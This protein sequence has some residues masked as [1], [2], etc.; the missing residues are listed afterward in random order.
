MYRALSEIPLP[1]AAQFTGDVVQITSSV[2]DNARNIKRSVATCIFVGPQSVSAAPAVDLGDVVAAISAPAGSVCYPRRAVLRETP[3][4]TRHVEISVG[5]ALEAS[6]EVTESHG[7]FY[8]DEF[9]S[10]LSFAPSQFAFMYVA[11]AKD[12]EQPAEKFKFTPPLGE[13]F[14]GKKQPA[15]FVFRWTTAVVRCET[16]LAKLSPS[17]IPHDHPVLF[18]QPVFS[19][20]DANTVYATGY[21]YTRDGR[22]LGP[23]WCYNRPSGIWEIAILSSTDDDQND[24]VP[25]CVVRKLTPSE[26]SCRSPRIYHDTASEGAT[27]Y[28]LS[29]ASG[30]PHAGTFS[31]HSQALGTPEATRKV[32]VDTVWEPR[33]SD[34]FPGLY[35]D[36]NLPLSPF[37]APDGKH[38]FLVF[39]SNWGSRT[40]VVLVSTLDGTVKDLTPDSDGKLFSWTVLA[41]DGVARFV[42]ARSAPAIP[43]EIVLGQLDATGNV[44]WRVIHTPHISPS[45]K[46]ALSALTSSVI[47]IPGRGQTQTMVVRPSQS[48][49]SAAP[50]CIQ[51]IHGGPHGAT[52]TAFFPN[53]VLLA[54]EGYTVSHPNYTGSLGF[55]E[56]SVRALLGKCG[57][58]DVQDCL[59][60]VRHLVT[61]GIAQEGKGKQFVVGGSH[62]GFLTAH[63]IGQYPD[64]FTAAVIRNPVIF[65]DAFSSDIPDWYFNEWKIEYPIYSSPLGFPDAV[66]EEARRALPP[67]RTPAQ[68]QEIFASAPIAHVDAVQAHVLLHLGG[69][70]RRVTP[71]H[72]VEYYHALKGRARNEGAGQV[73]EMQ[74]FEKEGHSLDGVEASR[75][76]AETTRDWF[77]KYRV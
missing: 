29:C 7:A 14:P 68:S 25:R 22:L 9:F 58:V 64:V 43:H 15:I 26:L 62:G 57:D 73:V 21:E 23:R 35:L 28:W 17:N 31:L 32:L 19:P 18:G 2:R 42:C 6:K 46:T 3:E 8:S 65:T 51:F 77:N 67:R 1:T 20:L 63:L 71:A 54:L 53:T 34:G 55:G 5:N 75:V 72:G 56:T 74:W 40:T 37:L 52:T 45:L 27:L 38:P 47:S 11:E 70:D 50:P 60:T 39:S 12:P 33:E 16:S 49:H 66:E 61:L 10:A 41:T 44:T 24:T 69:A 36:A 30:G 76:V 4:K 13:T 48:G 59:A